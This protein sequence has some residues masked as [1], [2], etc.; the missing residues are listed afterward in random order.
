MFRENCTAFNGTPSRTT[1]RNYENS[2][3]SAQTGTFLFTSQI[4]SVN[5]TGGLGQE[6]VRPNSSGTVPTATPP[7]SLSMPGRHK[8]GVVGSVKTDPGR[9]IRGVNT[10]NHINFVPNGGSDSNDVSLQECRQN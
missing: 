4:V 1:N 7:F 5:A 6:R 2:Q 8:R 9:G 3:S 10:L